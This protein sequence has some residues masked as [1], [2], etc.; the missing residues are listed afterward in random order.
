MLFPPSL[1]GVRILAVVLFL[2]LLDGL[3]AGVPRTRR[4]LYNL[5]GDSCLTLKA[6]RRGPGTI[7]TNDLVRLVEELTQPGSQVDTLLVCVNAQVMYFPTRVGTQR[8]TASTTEERARWSPHER[9]RHETV[10]RFLASG[11]DPWAVIVNAARQR[12]LEALMTFRMNDAHGNDFLR[13]TFWQDHPECRLPNGALDFS[14]AEV[15]DYVGTLIEE[16]AD[17]YDADGIELDFQRFPVFF[18]PNCPLSIAERTALID[19]LVERVRRHLDRLGAARGR[20][21]VLSARVPSDQ[22][23][24]APTPSQCLARG[25]DPAGWARRGWLDFLAVSEWLFTADS[26]DLRAWKAA[27]PGVPI[28]AGIQ[29]EWRP[30]P[31]GTRCEFCLGAEGYRRAARERWADGADGIYL[32]NFVTTREWPEPLEPPWEVLREIG[33]PVGLAKLP[34]APWDTNRPIATVSAE[35]YR[36]H[37]RPRSAALGSMTYVGPGLQRREW[38]AVQSRDDVAEIQE[39][40]WSGDNGRTWSEWIPQQ[41][42]SLVPYVGVSVWEGGWAELHDP[43]S[44]LLLQPWLRQIERHG[45]FHNRTYLRTSAD[46][47]RTWSPP[48]SLRYEDG[49]EFDPANP[50]AEEFLSRNQGYPGSNVAPL[51]DGSLVLALAHANATGDPKNETRAWRMGSILFRGRWDA[52]AGRHVWTAGARTEISPERSA[53]GLMEPEVAVLRDGRLLV[54]WRGSDTAW[55]G[56]RIPEPGRKW[57]AVSS[58]GGRTLSPVAPW[59]YSDGTEFYAASSIHRMIRHQGNG[60]LYWLGNLSLNP[61][62]GN[63][64][65]HPLVIAE[66]DEDAA[67]LR[68]DTVTVI[69]QRT[70]VQGPNVQYSNFSLLEDRETH[71][72]EIL[73]TTFGQELEPSEGATGDCWRY[74]LWLNP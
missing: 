55:D 63:H 19:G 49:P 70:P 59:R 17:R 60:R 2:G 14:R 52:A 73:L 33:D 44:G 15:R 9:Q 72:L 57:F 35:R 3:Q 65:R 26:L 28:Y 7:D 23:L 64:P 8:G 25:C 22:G 6:G 43:A 12:G 61:P 30:S 54:V 18:A 21:Y 29:P 50:A 48:Q 41:P 74:R 20:R 27:V 58:D 51:P 24:G 47:G 68:R 16:V 40:R 53:R 37:P 32:F 31:E 38:R 11:M 67:A 34:A 42:S 1:L 62:Q 56:T 13:T 5:D 71:A 10:E 46:Q 36:Q 45:R 4:I 69:A 39:A 66:V